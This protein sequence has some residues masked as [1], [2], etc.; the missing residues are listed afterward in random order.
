MY[1]YVF[2][3]N[4]VFSRV[5]VIDDILTLTSIESESVAIKQDPFIE[6]PGWEFFKDD[7][8]SEYESYSAHLQVS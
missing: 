7:V 6:F 1:F 2:L 4:F 3:R 8:I 5:K